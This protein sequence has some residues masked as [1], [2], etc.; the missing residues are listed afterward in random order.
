[1]KKVIFLDRDGVIIQETGS[2][3]FLPEHLKMVTGIEVFLLSMQKKGFEFI[4]ITNQGGI[5]KGYY[6]HEHVHNLNKLIAQHLEKNGI[7]F[8]DWFYCPHHDNY[9]YCLCRKPGSLML[10]KAIAKHEVDKANSLFIGD[11][12]SDAQAAESVGIKPVKISPNQDLTT[13]G[14]G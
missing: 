8:L 10:E 3:N 9:E 5:E 6:S 1:M 2:Y 7:T 13:L 4:T 14:F 12:D 11:K